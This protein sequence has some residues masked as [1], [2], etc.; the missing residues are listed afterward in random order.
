MAHPRHAD[1]P[2]QVLRLPRG[3]A[4]GAARAERPEKPYADFPL[5]PHATRR[6]A[7]RIRGQLHYFGPWADPD[8]ALGSIWTRR[9]TCT[10]AARPESKAKA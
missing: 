3:R 4:R 9:T 5:F 1:S 10:P 2:P 7:K 8:G 6:W